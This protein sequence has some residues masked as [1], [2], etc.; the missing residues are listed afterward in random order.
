MLFNSYEY[1]LVFLPVTVIVFLALGRSSRPL[2]LGWLILASVCFYAW[3]RP[4]NLAIIAPS[5]AINYALGRVLLGLAGDPAPRPPPHPPLGARHRLQRLLPRL[6]Q[7]RELRRLGGGRPERAGLRLQAGDPAARHL[8]H[9]LPE[10][11]LPDR[12]RRR[13]HQVLHPA[14]LSPLRDV[15]P[16][17]DRR[18][19]HPLRR[20][21]PAVPARHLPLRPDPLR[22]RHHALLLRALQEGGARRRHGRARDPGLRLCRL[23][24]R[25]DLPAVVAGGG[26]LHPADLLRLLRLFRHGLRR[27]ALL[28]DT[29]ADQLRLAAQGDQH[30]R[31]LAALAHHPDPLPDRLY[32]QPDG[33]DADPGAGGAAPADAARPRLAPAR[34]PARARLP[35]GHHHADLRAL[36]RGGLHLHPLGPAA[37]GLYRRQPP[38][39]AVRAAAGARGRLR[40]SRG[41]RRSSRASR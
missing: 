9:H 19:D 24:R 7:V 3:W 39:A 31:L 35:H 40:G 28:R 2:A 13:P 11:R 5:I 34:L 4:L 32:L 20:D 10:D 27:G 15:L 25:G 21:H 37:R 26:R 22:G 18:A 6:L 33:A 30:H 23:R 12:R 16:A 1:I 36:A 38:L 29:A 14:R 8:L 17:A 41:R